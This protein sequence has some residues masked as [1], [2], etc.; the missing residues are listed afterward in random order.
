MRRRLPL[1]S[2]G[3]VVYLACLAIAQFSATLVVILCGIV[4]GYY[5]WDWLP[6][7]KPSHRAEGVGGGEASS[8]QGRVESRHGADD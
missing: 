6:E 5:F 3:P 8:S 4:A 1:F 2:A 7:P